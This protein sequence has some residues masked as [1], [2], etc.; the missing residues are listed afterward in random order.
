MDAYSE[1]AKDCQDCVCSPPFAFFGVV[2]VVAIADV[3]VCYIFS[4]VAS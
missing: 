3:P 2:F 1:A 4:E